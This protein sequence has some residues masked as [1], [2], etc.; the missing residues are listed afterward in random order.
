MNY[1]FEIISIG[2][3]GEY[4]QLHTLYLAIEFTERKS[5]RNS[6]LIKVPVN[7]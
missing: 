6:I 1:L 4:R 2:H 5:F 3:F 7:I